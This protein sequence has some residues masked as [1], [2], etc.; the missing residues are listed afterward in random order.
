[1]LF[2]NINSIDEP[3]PDLLD[4]YFPSELSYSNYS[5]RHELE[6]EEL[7]FSPYS[8]ERE[9]ISTENEFQVEDIMTSRDGCSSA[10][11]Y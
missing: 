10:N 4:N 9:E 7:E 3:V 6:R 11:S 2:Q 1:M 8:F 5:F